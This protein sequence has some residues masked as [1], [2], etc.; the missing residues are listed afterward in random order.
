[1]TDHDDDLQQRRRSGRG[2]VS[3]TAVEADAIGRLGPSRRAR[4][5]ERRTGT[6]QAR[7]PGPTVWPALIVLGVALVV[8]IAG[9]VAALVGTGPV[10]TSPKTPKVVQAAGVP[11]A[12]VSALDAL[13]PI[14]TSGQPPA[15]VVAAVVLPTGATVSP[16]SATDLGVGL[17]DRSLA[18]SSPLS[19]AA[20]IAFYRA[21]L[22]VEGWKVISQGPPDHGP[23]FEILGQIAGTDG[24]YWE[25]G[26]VVSPTAYPAGS[27]SSAT[28]TTAFTLRLLAVDDTT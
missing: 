16:G 12:A 22:P 27:A 14:I 21:E 6:R 19:E 9:G 25:V 17:Y 24:Y 2:A 18:F 13:A 8:V 4:G 28:G 5:S 26:V 3:T 7:G 10:A 20:V 1:M 11:V 15:N 23:G